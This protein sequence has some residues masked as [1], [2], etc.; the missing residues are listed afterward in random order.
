MQG[1]HEEAANLRRHASRQVPQHP[2]IALWLGHALED[3]GQPEAAADAYRRA[4]A[5]MPDEAY[6][7]AQRLNW[8][9]RLC[10]WR[11][12]EA[13]SRQVRHAVAQG[14]PAV[15]PFAFLSEDANAIEQLACARQRAQVIAQSTPQL[16]ATSVRRHGPLRIGFLSNGFGAHPTGL[17]T[18]AL[19]EQ[20]RTQPAVQVH[21]F[22]LNRDDGSTIRQRL[23]AAAHT[24]HELSG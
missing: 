13:L 9:R 8:Q 10:D 11:D 6:M 19:F 18:V 12:L 5:L 3:A 7:A 22:A 24:L 4:Y 1:R 20:L 16:P 14:N 23:H 15:E 17:L 21:L 2:G